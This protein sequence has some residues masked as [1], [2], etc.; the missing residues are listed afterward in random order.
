M[1][2]QYLIYIFF[3]HNEKKY[4]GYKCDETSQKYNHGKNLLMVVNKFLLLTYCPN[5]NI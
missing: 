2:I 4:D 3:V 1:L 5:F